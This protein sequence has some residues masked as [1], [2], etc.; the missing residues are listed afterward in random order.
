MRAPLAARREPA[1]VQP[2]NVLYV[3]EHK[4]LYM[5][6]H[7]LQ[8]RAVAFWYISNIPPR[9]YWNKFVI[10]PLYFIWQPYLWNIA[11]QPTDGCSAYKL[12][13]VVWDAHR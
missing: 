9:F 1:G 5:L 6:I 2:L 4:T 10:I 11:I 12:M 13:Y 7:A 8:T 3:F